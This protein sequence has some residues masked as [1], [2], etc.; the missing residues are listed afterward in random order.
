MV[1]FGLVTVL[2]GGLVAFA[3]VLRAGDRDRPKLEPH[4]RGTSRPAVLKV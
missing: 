3:G 2:A 4:G 1:S